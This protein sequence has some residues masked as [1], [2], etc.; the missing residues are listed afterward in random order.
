MN[1]VHEPVM[2]RELLEYCVPAVPDGL[3]ID[4]TLG[5]GGH[6]AAFLAAHPRLRLVGVDAD[7]TMIHR[8]QSR[9]AQFEG[10][11]MLVQSWFD[12][13]F[14][15]GDC[16]QEGSD[17]P[18]A[19]ADR[20]GPGARPRG[21]QV[22]ILDLGVSM[23]HFRGAGRGFSLVE[24]G[25]LDMR[26]SPNASTTAADLVNGLSEAELADLIFRY[27]EERYSRR[28][29]AAICRNRPITTSLQL[30]ENIRAAVPP[31]YR[32]GRLHPATRTF[33]ALRI[34]VNDEL[35]RILRA[36]PAAATCLADGGS[37]GVISFHS[38]EDR[39]VK[40]VFRGLADPGWEPAPGNR[41]DGVF[42]EDLDAELG[43]VRSAGRT[44]SLVSKKPLTPSHEEISRN[45]AASSA[46]LRV[47]RCL[48]EAVA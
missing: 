48:A 14:A 36:L 43:A 3:M 31:A 1:L 16:G 2:T 15:R 32:R 27:G 8:A 40:R 26:L 10:R 37:L 7:P 19:E 11:T 13:Y 47:L 29:A 12:E 9:L 6:S 5:E 38:L 28:I 21:A 41:D 30:A 45:P 33:Q 17:P 4:G 35:A 24:D 18:A 23:F 46:K 22:I 39:L 44:F 25:P 20:P 42:A 34:V